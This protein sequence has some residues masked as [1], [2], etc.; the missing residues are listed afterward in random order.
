MKQELSYIC[1][2]CGQ[3]VKVGQTCSG[4]PKPRAAKSK[5]KTPPRSWEQDDIYDALDLPDDDFDYD[6]FVAKEFG[7]APHRR[8]GVK[9]YWWV[10][11]VITLIA[12]ILS[13]RQICFG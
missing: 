12:M 5:P 6:E 8:L 4:C 9:W 10:I 3:E 7:G 11:G 1:P 13:I 2:S